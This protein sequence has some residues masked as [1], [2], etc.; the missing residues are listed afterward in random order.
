MGDDIYGDVKSQEMVEFLDVVL[1]GTLVDFSEPFN[2]VLVLHPSPHCRSTPSG[3]KSISM[4]PQVCILGENKTLPVNLS[5]TLTITL[6]EAIL[7]ILIK[8]K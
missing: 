8:R 3:V 1:L 4:L 5:E 2:M 7:I 6:V